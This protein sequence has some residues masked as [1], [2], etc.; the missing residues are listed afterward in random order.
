MYICIYTHIFVIEKMT[1][2]LMHSENVLLSYTAGRPRCG[3]L[4]VY[5][6]TLFGKSVAA[7]SDDMVLEVI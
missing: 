5:G 1:V 3:L 2:R 7:G 4:L 6:I